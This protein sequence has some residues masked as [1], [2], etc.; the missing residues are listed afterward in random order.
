MYVVVKH[1]LYS[2]H[3][4]FDLLSRVQL[5]FSIFHKCHYPTY[6]KIDIHQIPEGNEKL[7]NNKMA[8]MSSKIN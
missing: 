3:F 5:T 4:C 7:H 1:D 8:F 6:E 2:C